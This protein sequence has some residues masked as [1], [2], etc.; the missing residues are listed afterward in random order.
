MNRALKILILIGSVFLIAFLYFYYN[1]QFWTHFKTDN[2]EKIIEYKSDNIKGDRGKQILIHKDFEKYIEQIDSYA[3]NNNIE[4][5]INHSYRSDEQTLS[6]AVVTPAE[7][8][9]HLA[10][11]AVDFNIKCNGI[12][13]HSIDLKS[14]N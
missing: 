3:L 10:G 2:F 6:S 11:F 4:L 7:L 13:Y 8:S 5:I 12:K 1:Y 9:N 14:N